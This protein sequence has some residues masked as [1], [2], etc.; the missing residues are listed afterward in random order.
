ML[1][2]LAYT[3]Y[4]H[5]ALL[6]LS[7]LVFVVVFLLLLLF[8]VPEPMER[9]VPENR[10]PSRSVSPRAVSP[11]PALHT[12]AAASSSVPPVL[13][14]PASMSPGPSSAPSSGSQ[15]PMTAAAAGGAGLLSAATQLSVLTVILT[16]PALTPFLRSFATEQ[17]Y[18][19]DPIDFSRTAAEFSQI[20]CSPHSFSLLYVLFPSIFMFTHAC[21]SLPFHCC[22]LFF[23]YLQGNDRKRE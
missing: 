12:S 6:L 3:C 21:L 20:V 17:K 11:Q 1:A 2:L 7:F 10:P 8:K 13:S 23:L 15:T 16:D 14:R 4:L 5:P 19:V 22:F 9:M 18:D